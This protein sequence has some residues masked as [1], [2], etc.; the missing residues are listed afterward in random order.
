MDSFWSSSLH[1]N[2]STYLFSCT[3]S[4]FWL[5]LP[6]VCSML[7]IG[8][9]LLHLPTNE[10]G[11]ILQSTSVTKLSCIT[12]I[13][14]TIIMLNM[15]QPHLIIITMFSP[16]KVNEDDLRNKCFDQ[17]IGFQKFFFFLFF[18]FKREKNSK[19]K[20]PQAKESFF[21]IWTTSERSSWISKYTNT[22]SFSTPL[23]ST[24]FRKLGMYKWGHRWCLRV[25]K[26]S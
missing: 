13:A 21:S 26:R 4:F 22:L 7:A 11:T 9:H 17:R 19:R 14:H 5:Y 16:G 2:H 12:Y 20:N 25:W 3:D 18:Q 6:N 15:L 24:M 8:F 10:R 23:N 1:I